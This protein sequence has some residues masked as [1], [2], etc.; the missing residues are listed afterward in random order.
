MLKQ[1]VK[2]KQLDYK[3]KDQ[4]VK[5]IRSGSLNVE[6]IDHEART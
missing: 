1:E 2:G 3:V 4:K 5:E 6:V